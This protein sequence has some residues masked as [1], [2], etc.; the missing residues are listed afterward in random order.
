VF[1]VAYRNATFEKVS[2]RVRSEL[3]KKADEYS[4]GEVLVCRTYFK[5]KK[6][7]F[8]VNYEY[9][10]TALDSSSTVQLNNTLLVP[11]DTLRKNFIHAYCRTCHSFQGTSLDERL[12]IFDWKFAHVNRKWLYTAVTRATELKNV[13]FYDY[14]ENAEKDGSMLQYF[15]RKVD[16]YKQQD[17]KAKREVQDHN[18]VTT[19]WLLS[20]LGKSCSGC[21]DALVYERGKSNLTAQRI[22]NT[23]A[24]ELDNVIPMCVFCNCALSN[25]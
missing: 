22:D 25:R 14:D 3:L 13:L 9:K 6:Q 17:R 1:N 5:I 7:V 20:C 23:V 24:H 12:T 15:G 10:I 8:N 21:G 18:Y 2:K 4:I 16:R 11:I 19:A